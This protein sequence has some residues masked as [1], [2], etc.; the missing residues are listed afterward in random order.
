MRLFAD[1]GSGGIQTGQG[2]MSAAGGY[3][4][5]TG[6]LGDGV[7]DI[8]A[9]LEDLAG[10]ISG[11][12]ATL[13][14]TIAHHSLTLPGATASGATVGPVAVDLGSNTVAGYP[15]IA[16]VSGTVGILGIP[17]V[18][19][20]T[21]G[22]QLLV[23]GTAGDDNA[24]FTPSGTDAGR[25]TRAESAQ[26]LNLT[27]RRRRARRRSRGGTDTLTV[28]GTTGA[29]AVTAA[30]DVVTTVQVNAL[31]ATASPTANVERFVISTRQGVDVITPTVYDT[32]SAS[33]LVDGGDPAVNKPN[34][35]RLDVVAGSPRPSLQNQPGGPNPGSGSAF[36]EYPR[37]T[38]AETRID[39]VSVEK[40]TLKK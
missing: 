6:P 26:V 24:V 11:P 2:P 13:R 33:L 9:T 21:G 32:V 36:V 20:D 4:L 40:V 35:D 30:V 1:D 29:D 17:T 23:L 22:Q 34:G 15:G 39:Y 12:S 37:T 8:T 27:R 3:Q 10:N 38:G 7:Y 5:L 16:G 14:V 18:N 25:M 28:V 19:I 31:L